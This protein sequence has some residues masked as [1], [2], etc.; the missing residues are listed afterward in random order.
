MDIN[1]IISTSYVTHDP[2]TS[3]SKLVGTFEDPTVTGVVIRGDKYV[4]MVT[5]R[6]LATSRHQPNEKL[7]SIAQSTPRVSP[8]E[9]IRRVARLMVD[10]DS[11]ML[12][13]FEGDNLLG[14][15]TGRDILEA[16]REFLEVAAV[17]D[18]CSE[19]LVAVS[20][21]STFGDVVHLFRDNRIAHLPVVDDRSAVGILSLYDLVDLRI[22]S[23]QQ[24]QGGDV[25]GVDAHGGSL[26]GRSRG[27]GFGA[28]EGE[29]QRIL[30]LP[31]R[32]VMTS[33]V[34]T[35]EWGTTLDIAVGEMFD[36]GGSSLV[37]TEDGEPTGIVTTTD[38]LDALTWE[39]GGNRAVQLYGI[40]LLDDMSYDQV[41]G[42]IERFDGRDGQMSVFD[43]KI[44]L[45][46]HDEKL[47]GTPMILARIRLYTDR[48]LFMASG[49]GFGAKQALTEARDRLERRI[50]D[51]KT[52][53]Q[54]KKPPG[55]DFWERRF[56]W[57]L[58]T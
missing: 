36:I 53:G 35:V 48:G 18:V 22:R 33:P 20:P 14:V 46:E 42:M 43:A 16:V 9:D 17:G 28:R 2:D 54:S 25:S 23:M 15:I 52:H 27:G 31:V 7:G 32:D 47:R 6:H 50:I 58:E 4:G 19:D 30:D 49:E 38:I 45:H 26:A 55:E 12:P 51:Q 5:R 8:T 56:G 39:A 41:V 1:D 44:H 24:S 40:D 3:I 13:V 34:A 10:S 57:L 29:L 37:V 11:E 21:D